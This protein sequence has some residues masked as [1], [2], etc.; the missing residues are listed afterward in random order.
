MIKYIHLVIKEI[1]KILVCMLAV[2]P[3]SIW[4]LITF[5]TNDWTNFLEFMWKDYK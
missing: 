1:F 2:I 3:F 5:D 4:W